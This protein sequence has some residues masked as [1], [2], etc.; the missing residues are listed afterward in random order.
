[1]I[2]NRTTMLG[3]ITREGFLRKK[4]SCRFIISKTVLYTRILNILFSISIEILIEIIQ[5]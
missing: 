4:H 1:M 2:T 5:E 3:F